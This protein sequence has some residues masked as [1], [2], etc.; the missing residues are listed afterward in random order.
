MLCWSGSGLYL[1]AFQAS[2]SQ[3]T[4]WDL[5][6]RRSRSVDTFAK[7]LVWIEFGDGCFAVGT[8]KGVVMVFEVNE[9]KKLVRESGNRGG[10]LC[11]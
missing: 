9:G 4:L 2:S 8:G 3:V 6:E 7:D 5:D 1:A 10:E 11:F